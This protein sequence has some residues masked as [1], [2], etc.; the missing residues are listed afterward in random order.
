MK[1]SGQS[2]FIPNLGYLLSSWGELAS[3]MRNEIFYHYQCYFYSFIDRLWDYGLLCFC[4]WRQNAQRFF[5]W[6]GGGGRRH[7]LRIAINGLP[8]PPLP[9][10]KKKKKKN[11]CSECLGA[12]VLCSV[13]GILN[14]TSIKYSSQRETLLSDSCGKNLKCCHLPVLETMRDIRIVIPALS[15]CFSSSSADHHHP[16]QHCVLFH[17]DILK[18]Q[19]LWSLLH[20]LLLK[21]SAEV[22]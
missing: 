2:L 10:K 12:T 19:L 13:S 6:G 15:I 5:F 14:T 21:R 3:V 22:D 8:P 18:F 9:P 17:K 20:D 11:P 7:Y 1:V 4:Q 16:M